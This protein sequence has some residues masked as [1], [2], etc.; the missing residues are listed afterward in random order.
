MTGIVATGSAGQWWAWAALRITTAAPDRAPVE[1]PDDTRVVNQF[2]GAARN[3]AQ[4]GTIG[5][6]HFHVEPA[7]PD[8]RPWLRAMGGIAAGAHVELR[9]LR[10]P[11]TSGLAV[12]L[13]MRVRGPERSAAIGVADGLRRG[14]ADLPPR[15]RA[16]PV[17]SDAELLRVLDPFPP[18]ERG[19]VEIR[20]CVAIARPARGDTNLPWLSTVTPFG[21][22]DSAWRDLLERLR[23]LPDRAMLSVG[24]APFRVGAGLRAHLAARATELGRLARP[25]PPPTGTWSVGRPPDPFAAAAEPVF[26]DALRRY[27]GLAFVG[28]VSLA[29]EAAVPDTLA[30]ALAATVAPAAVVRPVGDEAGIARRNLTGLAFD[31]LPVAHAQ[32]APADAIG[33][34]ERTLGSIL[35]VD[36]AAAVFR[37]PDR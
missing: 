2:S 36:E 34:L 32:G 6:V 27:A 26:T 19:L 28:R 37:L 31:P 20:K 30:E 18:H 5:S 4:A 29:A 25:G 23:D 35:D 1:V 22:S 17:G 13:A 33:D 8:D 24:L 11:A 3:V 7:A 14:L 16:E 21:R 15:C 12:F 9:Y 10:D